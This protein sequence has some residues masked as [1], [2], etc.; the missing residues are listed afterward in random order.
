MI[1]I[2]LLYKLHG[3]FFLVSSINDK[4]D[5]EKS[6]DFPTHW[7]KSVPNV[8]LYFV[9]FIHV[10]TYVMYEINRKSLTYV[11]LLYINLVHVQIINQ[12]KPKNVFYLFYLMNYYAS[13]IKM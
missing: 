11:T 13:L 8:F 2:I 12:I 9:P 10:F 4:R 6:V 7:H 1:T 3:N 5:Q